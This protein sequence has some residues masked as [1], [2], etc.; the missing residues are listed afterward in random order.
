M[1]T[2]IDVTHNETASRFETLIEGQLSVADYHTRDGV[3]T[4]NHTG[5]PSALE[6]RGI[7]SALVAAALDHARAQG[8]KV[9]PDCWYVARWMKR[10]PES[11][12][13]LAA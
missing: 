4:M 8:L 13:L 9:Q 5:V 12:D 7:A 6:G 2:T 3:M 10:H 11:L 1:T